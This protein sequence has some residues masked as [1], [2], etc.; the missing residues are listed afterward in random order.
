MVAVAA[1]VSQPVVGSGQF[2]VVVGVAIVVGVAV[3]VAV[4]VAVMVGVAVA[5]GIGIAVAVG[6]DMIKRNDAGANH[7]EPMIVARMYQL[8]VLPATPVTR[9]KKFVPLIDVGTAQAA[10]SSRINAESSSAAS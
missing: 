9:T 6:V 3:A 5:I 1:H 8:I 7:T 2:R 10:L 4:A